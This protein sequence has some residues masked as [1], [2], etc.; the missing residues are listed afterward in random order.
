M[1]FN[2][3]TYPRTCVRNSLRNKQ[4]II[5]ENNYL[6]N[7]VMVYL[8]PDQFWGN[9]KHVKLEQNNIIEK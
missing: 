1:F 3:P 8:L 4:K 2:V 5:L 9:S 7:V 6:K